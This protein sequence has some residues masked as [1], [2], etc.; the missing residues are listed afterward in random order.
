LNRGAEER[1]VADHDLEAVVRRVIVT[2]GDHDAAVRLQVMHAEVQG[3]RRPDA[4]VEQLCAAALQA[5]G[6]RRVQAR[7]RESA[8]TADGEAWRFADALADQL[9]DAASNALDDVV[10]KVAL[11]DATDV[12]LSK[13]VPGHA[14]GGEP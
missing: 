9:S 12:I 7:S 11:S 3:R 4:D 6:Q 10:G 2:A 5:L 8:V 14:V 13:N 1:A